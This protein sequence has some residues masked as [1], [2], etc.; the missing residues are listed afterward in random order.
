V[1]LD[2]T[3][4]KARVLLVLVP[5]FSYFA[6]RRSVCDR[7][8]INLELL[9][10]LLLQCSLSRLLAG[11]TGETWRTAPS[12]KRRR[13]LAVNTRPDWLI[14]MLPCFPTSSGGLGTGT[15]LGW[16]YELASH[17]VTSPHKVRKRF[18]RG[19]VG[20][21]WAHFGHIRRDNG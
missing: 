19:S 12:K 9:F 4:R 11:S 16:V 7:R 2:S 3:E 15:S 21:F 5:H 17:S 10:D 20:T 8:L 14:A 1:P 18:A 13:A 6:D